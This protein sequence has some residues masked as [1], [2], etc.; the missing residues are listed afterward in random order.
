[1]TAP[2]FLAP[3]VLV[4]G[5]ETALSQV[6]PGSGLAVLA[7][8]EGRHASRV[9]RL[10]P[11]ERVDLVDGRGLRLIAEVAEQSAASGGL[12]VKPL[13]VVEEP[14]RRPELILVQALAKGGRDE[15]A[16]E[17]ATELG[18]DCV[19]PWAADRSVVRWAPPKAAK[20]L[21]RWQRILAAATK[22]SR[23]ASLP[24][25]EQPVTSKQLAA[26]I[27]QWVGR[28]DLVLVCHEEATEKLSSVLA[29]AAARSGLS[30]MEDRE[31]LVV[32]STIIPAGGTGEVARPGPASIL[33]GGVDEGNGKRGRVVVLVGP[34][35]GVS[36]DE[37]EAFRSAG[38]IPVLLGPEVLRSSTAGPAALVAANLAFGRW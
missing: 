21:E 37:L 29:R 17:T 18:V 15:Q 23:R 19:I 20:S 8:D 12:V 26:R 4:A 7:G 13:Q 2:V 35:G 24:L 25:L 28:G 30:A 10:Q 3:S 6:S 27:G 33:D 32:P 22:Q 31:G 14:V 11:G 38:A 5:H 1:M 36:P 34:E 9:Q 16:I